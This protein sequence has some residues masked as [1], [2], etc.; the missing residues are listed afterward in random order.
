MSCTLDRSYPGKVIRLN[1]NVSPKSIG[2]LLDSTDSQYLY[3]IYLFI[4]NSYC[5]TV[6]T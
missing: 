1:P 5:L 6:K 4:A 2:E 3:T